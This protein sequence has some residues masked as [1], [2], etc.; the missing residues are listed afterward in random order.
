MQH[1]LINYLLATIMGCCVVST[2]LAQQLTQVQSFGSNPGN[3]KMYVYTPANLDTT[4]KVPLVV[5][6]HGCLQ[7][8]NA[9]AKQTGWNKLA[10]TYGFKVLYPQQRILNNPQ[11][12]FCWYQ[13]NDIEKGKGESFSI[14][15]MIDEVKRSGGIDSAR[16]FITGLSAGA[17]M[18]VALMAD[19]PETFNAG[20]IFAGGAYKTA[21][22]IWNGIL[23]LYGF[24]I[25]SPEKWGALVR[26]QNPGYHGAYPRMII[27]QGKADV[28][29]N[30][31]NGSQL[32][33]QWTNLHSLSTT[34][35]VTIR[36][37]AGIK[38]IEK[39]IY[40]TPQGIDAVLYYR[41]KHLGHALLVDP[42]KCFNQGGRRG[43]FSADKNYFS[44][45]WTAIDFGLISIPAIQ[46]KTI[47]SENETVTYTIAPANGAQKIVWSY[48][49]G[50]TVVENKGDN[51]LTLKWGSKP[52]NIN[53]T[54]YYDKKCKQN[55][56]TLPVAVQ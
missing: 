56:I 33:K 55:Y 16:V 14:K 35:T 24:R 3:L 26:E 13:R 5:V 8:A 47:V 36:R 21:T 27:Y 15:Q 45:Y 23:S 54:G 37:F 18:G 28:V 48:P 34:P 50:C 40:R 2:S 41:I 52:G 42:G 10:D 4:K 46:G 30:K 9:A 31:R 6:L 19:Y 43:L 38:A 25:K 17:A 51:H 29:V 7:S 44:T 32:M 39:N 11:K 53:A 1:S 22:N 20:A 49:K 12:C